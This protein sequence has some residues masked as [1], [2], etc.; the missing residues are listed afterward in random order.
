VTAWNIADHHPVFMSDYIDSVG[1]WH[2]INPQLINRT[3]LWHCVCVL[4]RNER[5][6]EE[7]AHSAVDLPRP[8]IAV[9]QKNLQSR[10]RFLVVIWQCDRINPGWR[11]RYFVRET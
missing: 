4:V 11:R 7:F 5:L 8:E 2:S 10:G 6:P 1:H 3:S 9:V